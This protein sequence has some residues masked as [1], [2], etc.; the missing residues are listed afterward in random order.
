MASI[1]VYFIKFTDNFEKIGLIRVKK[2][3]FK[4][5]AIRTPIILAV[6]NQAQKNLNFKTLVIA[7]YFFFSN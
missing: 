5:K 6:K 7:N 2:V 4:L 1:L 3:A